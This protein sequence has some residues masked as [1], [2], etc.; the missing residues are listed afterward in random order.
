MC[1]FAVVCL[2]VFAVCVYVCAFVFGV[3]VLMRCVR[4]WCVCVVYL[5]GVWRAFLYEVCAC[6]FMEC[7][8]GVLCGVCVC[9]LMVCVVCVCAS[10]CGV[11]V[12]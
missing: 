7:T 9:V 3:G 12:L 1:V 10:V 4:L 11:C 2:S 8:C 6:V 5:C